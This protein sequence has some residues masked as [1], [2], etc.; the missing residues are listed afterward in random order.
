MPDVSAMQ[1]KKDNGKKIFNVGGKPRE[2]MFSAA[3]RF[4]LFLEVPV[5][6]V[7]DYILSDLF[8]INSVAMI[9]YGKEAQGK[10]IN[11]LLDKFDDDELSDIELEEIV[12]WVR[13]RTLNFMLA[14]AQETI[15]ALEPV[16]RQANELNNTSNGILA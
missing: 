5:H 4:R 14:E 11:D 2:V 15:K 16:L 7:Q 6:E 3:T 10:T 13:E 12:G 1:V 9:L 8:K